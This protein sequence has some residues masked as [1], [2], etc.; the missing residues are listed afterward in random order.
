MRAERENIMKKA[1]KVFLGAALAVYVLVLIYVLFLRGRG[2]VYMQALPLDEYAKLA[3]NLEP[4]ETIKVF[5]RALKENRINTDIALLNIFGNIALFVP[6][7]FL[8]P[9][10]EKNLRSL[11]KCA[12]VS[13]AVIVVVESLQLLFKVG[14]FDVDD[15]ILNMLGVIIGYA[16]Y[17]IGLSVYKKTSKSIE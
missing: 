10:F 9:L 5:W 13:L 2:N 3:V 6:F 16:V 4:F 17:K 12:A 7:G 11:L 8:I 1:L 14:S 15:I